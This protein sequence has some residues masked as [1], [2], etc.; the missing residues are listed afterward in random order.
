MGSLCSIDDF[1]ISSS[2]TSFW[3]VFNRL[4]SG[5]L[6]ALCFFSVVYRVYINIWL[7]SQEFSQSGP[8]RST[9]SQENSWSQ[10]IHKW[11]RYPG[12]K[13]RCRTSSVNCLLQTKLQRQPYK[14]PFCLFR[15]LTVY[16]NELFTEFI[17]ISGYDPKSFRKV[18]LDAQLLAKKIVG[19]NLFINDFD[20][21]EGK[22]VVEL[23][24]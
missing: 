7:R 16:L 18:A 22:Y 12:R 21:Q 4:M 23:A 5:S 14:D 2:Y 17:L 10:F 1:S 15:A 20:I 6:F 9:S 8:W 11:L 19:R 3:T 24:Q 13:I